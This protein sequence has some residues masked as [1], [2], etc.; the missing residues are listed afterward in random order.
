MENGDEIVEVSVN[1]STDSDGVGE[2]F[3]DVREASE[4]SLGMDNQLQDV[5]VAQS[6]DRAYQYWPYGLYKGIV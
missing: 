3:M 1:I 6:L 5:S 2:Y 4:L